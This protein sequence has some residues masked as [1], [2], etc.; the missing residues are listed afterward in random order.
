MDPNNYSIKTFDKEEVQQTLD[1]WTPERIAQAEPTQLELIKDV[2]DINNLPNQNIIPN[3]S[4]EPTPVDVS[5]W[6]FKLGGQLH[7]TDVNDGK[8]KSCTA[9]IVGHFNVLLTAAHCVRDSASGAYHTNFEFH[10]GYREGEA[11]E[12]I[13]IQAVI[14][15][16]EWIGHNRAYDYAFCY[17]TIKMED[18]LRFQIGMP[19]QDVY[20]IGYPKVYGNGEIM[21]MVEGKTWVDSREGTVAMLGNAMEGGGASGGAWFYNFSTTERRNTNIIVGINSFIR[22]YSNG[23]KVMFSPFFDQRVFNLFNKLICL[24]EE[25]DPRRC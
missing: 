13:P 2:N 6:P 1:Y 7:Y 25:E 17:T 12:I 24:Q 20:A 11:E 14:T 16:E 18:Y 15:H 22:E 10:K 9:Q 21:H 8:S 4:N 3:K 23:S 5:I 19:V